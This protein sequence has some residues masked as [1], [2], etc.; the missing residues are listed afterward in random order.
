MGMDDVRLRDVIPSDLDVFLVHEHDAEAVRRS[1]F[2]PRARDAF[3]AH[4]EKKILGD[5]ECSV[6]TVVVDGHPAGNILSWPDA[7]PAPR[8]TPARTPPRR[9]LGYWLG[10]AYWGR[11]IGTAA[12]RLYLA[13]VEYVRPLY[14][15][16]HVGNTAS[17]RLLERLG[18]RPTGPTGDISYDGDGDGAVETDGADEYVL[19]AL[20]PTAPTPTP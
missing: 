2:V 6:R 3:L 20:P 14:A 18:F 15:D 12:L 19:L 5:P 11:G 8:A 16:V 7:N 4:W 9:F 10:S 13:D 17:I 1:R